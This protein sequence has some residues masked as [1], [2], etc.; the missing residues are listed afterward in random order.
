MSFALPFALALALAR[1]FGIFAR[2]STI[3]TL[4][5]HLRA[6]ADAAAIIGRGVTGTAV[7][8]ARLLSRTARIRS[9]R[10]V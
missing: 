9:L 2:F 6:L 3:A 10:L 1:L 5:A 7:A 8:T 4:L